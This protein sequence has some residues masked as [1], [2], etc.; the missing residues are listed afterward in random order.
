[1]KVR[2]P[3]VE[4]ALEEITE[5]FAAGFPERAPALR[6]V[7]R[8]A[9]YPVVAP[10]GRAAEVSRLWP[11]L[12][13][14]GDCAPV[15]DLGADG[16][17]MLVGVEAASWSCVAEVGRSTVEL[18]AGPRETLRELARDMEGALERLKEAVRRA[19]LRLLGFGIQPRARA[20]RRLLTPKLRYLA[21]LEAIGPRWLKFCVTAA[22]QVQVDM[23]RDELVRNTNVINAASGAM[24]SLTANSSVYAGRAGAFASG[25]E[26]LA[27]NMLG[28]THRHGSSPQPY[29]DLGEYVRFLAGLRCLCLP[30]SGGFRPVGEPFAEYLQNGGPVLSSETVY[31]EFLFHEHYVWPSARPRSR[32][33]TL[34]VRPACQQPAESTWVPSALALGLVEAAGEV[35]S[36]FEDAFGEDYWDVL[37]RYRESAV[38]H[39]LG[40]PAPV[41][42][43]LETLLDLARDGLRRRGRNEETFLEPAYAVLDRGE[44]PA[45]RAR[46]LFESGGPEALVR[47]LSLA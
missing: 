8:E 10:D 39:G 28:E 2:G 5:R 9:E 7:G 17:K 44:E 16:T 6:T 14:R 23:G 25:R 12:L 34:E 30:D 20:S 11:L 47:E 4:K 37:L 21:L 41:P 26:G 45:S 27:A 40:A 32:I 29:A 46:R 43:F 36:F 42:R 13:E 33:G 18:S 3:R 19:G 31:E 38:R 1:M 22:D 15:Y 24:I 35:Q